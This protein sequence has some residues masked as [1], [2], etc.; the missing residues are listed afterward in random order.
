MS[1]QPTTTTPPTERTPETPPQ[2]RKS[3]ASKIGGAF[4]GLTTRKVAGIPLVYIVLLAGAV[5]LFFALRMSKNTAATQPQDE[6]TAPDGDSNLG[7]PGTGTQPGFSADDGIGGA[8][9]TPGNPDPGTDTYTDNAAWGAAAVKFLV[10]AGYTTAEATTAV[11]LYLYGGEMSTQQQV[12]IDQAVKALGLP[13]DLTEPTKDTGTAPYNGP[14][15]RQGVPPLYHTV[16]GKSDDSPAELTLLYYGSTSASAVNLLK[17]ATGPGATTNNQDVYPAGTKVLVPD[18]TTGSTTG[19][20]PETPAYTPPSNVI[21]PKQSPVIPGTR[22]GDV[23][24]QTPAGGGS[25]STIP[26]NLA[27]TPALIG[28][29]RKNESLTDFQTRMYNTHGFTPTYVQLQNLNPSKPVT[30]QK[31]R[32]GDAHEPNDL[33]I[34]AKG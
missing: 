3:V 14:A 8:P 16:K 1:E 34:K 13:P 26:A 2:K 9:G 18:Y 12:L 10:T 19:A 22:P 30:L 25:V 23:I 11:N 21:P 28:Q 33:I 4:T 24:N 6:T 31:M 27:G 32:A 7:Y 5:A 15:A 20:S 17:S 29:V